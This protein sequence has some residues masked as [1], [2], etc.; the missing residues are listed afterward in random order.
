MVDGISGGGAGRA[1]IDAALK[2][3]RARAEELGAKSVASGAPNSGDAGAVADGGSFAAKLKDGLGAVEASVE[4]TNEIH[5][6]VVE[7]R[8]DIHEVAAQLKE[9]E[10]TFQFALQV[11]NKLLDSYREVMRMSV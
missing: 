9:S 6:D 7:G 4:R 2:N 1:A 11:R 5:L 10:I 3:L 8:V